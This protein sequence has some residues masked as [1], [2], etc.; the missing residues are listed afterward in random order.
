MK[1]IAEHISNTE[2]WCR[3]INELLTV[4]SSSYKIK[5]EQKNH[6]M[7]CMI[8]FSTRICIYYK[9]KY[10][11]ETNGFKFNRYKCKHFMYRCLHGNPILVH[12]HSHALFSIPNVNVFPI[13]LWLFSLYVF[14]AYCIFVYLCHDKTQMEQRHV[15]LN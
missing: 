4:S 7:F 2:E 11:Y 10:K 8:F 6:E 9:Y 3:I 14:S 13:L 15:H 12:E 1:K 5:Y